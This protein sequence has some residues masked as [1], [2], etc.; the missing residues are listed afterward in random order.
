[1]INMKGEEDP[2]SVT[3]PAVKAESAVRCVCA[4]DQISHWFS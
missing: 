2:L 3:L 1:M 4:D